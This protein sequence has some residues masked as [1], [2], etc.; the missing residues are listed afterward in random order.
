MPV[1]SRYLCEYPGH[2]VAMD[3]FPHHHAKPQDFTALVI[4]DSFRNLYAT[5]SFREIDLSSM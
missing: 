2:V 4:A 3:M 5:D 1:V